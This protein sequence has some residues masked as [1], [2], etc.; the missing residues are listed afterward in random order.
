MSI[1]VGF[2]GERLTETRYARQ[3]QGFGMLVKS[4]ALLMSRLQRADAD[5]TR[6]Y[7]ESW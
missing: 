4:I 5:Y 6:L 3:A 7:I 2:L 1:L